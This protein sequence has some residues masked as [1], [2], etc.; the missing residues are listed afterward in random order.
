MF[1]EE[2]SQYIP[3]YCHHQL[4]PTRMENRPAKSIRKNF[5]SRPSIASD[6]PYQFILHRLQILRK[7]PILRRS[8]VPPMFQ[9]LDLLS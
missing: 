1:F 6:E 8:I 5:A 7:P 3:M 2:E 9:A 4:R